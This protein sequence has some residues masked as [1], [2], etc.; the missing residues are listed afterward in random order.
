MF[1]FKY[2]GNYYYECVTFEGRTPWCAT[3][4]DY[5]QDLRWGYCTDIKCFRF[6]SDKKIFSEARKVCMKDEAS[7]VS[8]H[9]SIEQCILIKYKINKN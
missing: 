9:S 4:F 5:D 7:L 3:T 8:I 1:P 6:V 2:K